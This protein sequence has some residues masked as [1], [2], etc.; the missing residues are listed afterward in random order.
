MAG[1][2]Q[3]AVAARRLVRT[4]APAEGGGEP[5]GLAQ[6]RAG[7]DDGGVRGIVASIA[8]GLAGCGG[9]AGRCP[10]AAPAVGAGGGAGT[11][12]VDAPVAPAIPAARAAWWR[13]VRDGAPPPAGASADALVPELEAMLA[14]PDPV[15]RDELAFGVL[16][17]WLA[18]DGPLSA[19]AVTGL[20]ERL[21]ARTAA[22]AVAGDAVF[23]RSFA[24]LA[25][26]AIAAREVAAPA[27]TDAELDA[28]VTAAVAYAGH[29]IDLRGHTGATG[30]A[31]AA[32]HT[33]DW[34]KFLARHPRLDAGQASH[35][36]AGVTAL[37]VR[38]DAVRYSHGEDERLA[39]AVRA[40]VRRGL[41][42][43]AAVDA[44]L[45][46]VAAPLAEGFPDPYDAARCAAQRNARDLL[47]SVFVA[48][49]FD[50]A[51]GAAAALARLRAFMSR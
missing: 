48:L 30:W 10:P 43:D 14:S 8:I 40:V 23:A 44:W 22:P 7:G 39:A 49:S 3:A 41:L 31:H 28:Q 25:L 45:A 35:L 11:P 27:W 36:L 4:A 5:G 32:A 42:A 29:E 37:I 19:A 16:A 12:A 20:R 1:L 51:P 33:A 15:A 9:P 47:V 38:R 34:M 18:A 6:R 46:A 17:R 21:T 13:A 2:R 26:S 24:A 50:P